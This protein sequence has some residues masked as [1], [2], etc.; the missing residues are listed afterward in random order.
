[1]L[2]SPLAAAFLAALSLA[3]GARKSPG[4]RLPDIVSI[5]PNLNDY[6]RFADGGPD[7]NWYIGFN[8]AWI[9]KL[10]PAPLEDFSRAFI[11]AKIGRAKTRPRTSRPWER[12]VIPGKVYIGISDKPSFRSDQS[13]FLAETDDIPLEVDPRVSLQGTGASQWF[14]AEIPPTHVNLQGPNYLILWSPTEHFVNASSAP[15]VAAAETGSTGAEPRAWINRSILGVPPRKADRTLE[16]PINNLSPALAIKL[17]PNNSSVVSVSECSV[18]TLPRNYLFNFSVG[19]ENVDLAWVEM[20][21][22]QLEWEKISRFARQPPY[23]FTISPDRL[24]QRGA[25]LRASAKDALGNTGSC[26]PVYV[27]NELR[28]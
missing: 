11:G 8:N 3:Y 15:I 19:G 27:Q 7:E 28:Q 22:D 1:M 10:P 12:E 9:V 16:T 5:A 4:P 13:F 20:S 23:S 2:I 24:P 14:W 6:S 21:R 26:D 25:Y 17:V 18:R